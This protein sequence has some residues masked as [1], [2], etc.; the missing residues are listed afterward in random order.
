MSAGEGDRN[1]HIDTVYLYT[2]T[3]YHECYIV[4]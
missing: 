3:V 1:W 2:Y 4:H